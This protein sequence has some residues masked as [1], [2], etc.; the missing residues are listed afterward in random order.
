MTAT[1]RP[2]RAGVFMVRSPCSGRR[3]DGRTGANGP[4]EV[5]REGFPAV[6]VSSVR[7]VAM[8]GVCAETN[9]GRA[10]V[11]PIRCRLGALKW[12]AAYREQRSSFMSQ[13]WQHF[14]HNGESGRQSGYLGLHGHSVPIKRRIA[15][16]HQLDQTTGVGVQTIEPGS[17]A[18]EAGVLEGDVVLQL[19]GE[20]TRCADELHQL[21][22]RLP[23]DMPLSLIL[24]RG[25]RCLERL[26]L[27][28]AFPRAVRRR[29]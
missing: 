17:P 19:A 8:A 24:L 18:E 13:F 28:S 16:R 3:V 11:C 20:P 6:P 1:A 25:E 14:L 10:T 15:S 22:N 7:I 2:R 4:R 27:T 12:K 23:V 5:R 21:L 9:P 26:V 29:A